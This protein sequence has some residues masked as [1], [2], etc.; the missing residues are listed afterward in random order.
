VTGV[1][2]KGCVPWGC[3]HRA[4]W[5]GHHITYNFVICYFVTEPTYWWRGARDS[6]PYV[7]VAPYPLGVPPRHRN[8]EP[9]LRVSHIGADRGVTDHS[10]VDTTTTTTRPDHRPRRRRS[11]PPPAGRRRRR[12]C[13]EHRYGRPIDTCVLL[14][15][16]VNMVWAFC[17]STSTAR[18]Q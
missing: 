16:A 5:I 15:S 7:Y 8:P 10:L 18:K 4:P 9:A 14:V 3:V 12:E 11:V 17:A 6:A 13:T 2:T 1:I